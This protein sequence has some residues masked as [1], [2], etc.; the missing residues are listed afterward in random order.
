MWTSEFRNALNCLRFHKH[1]TIM[2]TV[3]PY[4]SELFPL[5]HVLAV[6]LTE[7]FLRQEK[8]SRLEWFWVLDHTIKISIHP[9]VVMYLLTGLI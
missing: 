4:I 5:N 1:K 9:K 7:C 2:N 6:S 8:F 3:D